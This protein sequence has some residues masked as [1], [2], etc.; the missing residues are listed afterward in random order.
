MKRNLSESAKADWHPS[1][2][3]GEGATHTSNWRSNFGRSGNVTDVI[4]LI[5]LGDRRAA[6]RTE[7]AKDHGH[8]PF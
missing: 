5:A 7:F 6:T 4:T 1:A 3:P 2:Q 8:M